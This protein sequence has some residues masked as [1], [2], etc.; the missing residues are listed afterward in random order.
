MDR[1]ILITDSSVLTIKSKVKLPPLARIIVR[2]GSKLIVDG[3]TLTNA[4]FSMWQG[5]QVWGHYNL[6]QGLPLQGC[7]IFKNGAVVENA[8]IGV[9]ACRTDENGEIDWRSTGGIIVGDSCIFRN[10][11]EAVKF[12]S[13]NRTNS[14]RFRKVVFETTREF[15]DGVSTPVDF[16][17][18]FQVRGV[19]F[20]GCTFRNTTIQPGNLPTLLSG[21]GIY[22]INAS[23]TID[24]DGPSG[25]SGLHYGIKAINADPSYWINIKKSRFDGNYRGIYLSA[26]DFAQVTQDT[27][28]VPDRAVTSDTCYGLYLD[29]CTAY[30]VQENN[31]VSTFK[32]GDRASNT[33]GIVVDNS[34]TEPNE[35]YNNRFTNIA[36]GINSQ[37]INRSSNGMTGLI[38]KCNDFINTKNDNLVSISNPN[39]VND[40]GIA[41]YQGDSLSVTGP[42]GNTFSPEH[43]QTQLSG[44]DVNNQG[45]RFKYYH[46]H[47]VQGQLPRVKPDFSLNV[48]VR[49]TGWA[50]DSTKCCPSKLNGGGI[51]TTDL[52][53]EMTKESDTIINK[54]LQLNAIIDGGNTETLNSEILSSTPP[55]SLE[56]RDQLLGKSPYLSDTTM[57]SAISKED[58]LPNEIIRD[59]LV[60]NPQSATSDKVLAE[61]NNRYIPM[62]DSMMAEI[63]AGEDIVSAKEAMEAGLASH[64]V[65]RAQALFDL[66]NFYQN[67]TINPSSHD[68][69][70][71]I[72]QNQPD[73][74]LKYR[75]AFK[76]LSTGDT[77]SLN[78]TLV[79]IPL[80]RNLDQQETNVHNDYLTYFS[81]MKELARNN[82]S[83]LTID[84]A[85]LA[86]IQNL[87]NT[88]HDPVRSIVR[89]ILIARGELNYHEPILLPDMLKSSKEKK[90]YMTGKFVEKTYMRIFPNPARQ[91]V[92][93]EYNLKEKFSNNHKV[94]LILTNIKGSPVLVKKLIK[95]QDQELINTSDFT[96]GTY[97]CSLMLNGKTLDNKKLVVLE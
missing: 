16:I 25:F 9:A 82:K 78:N 45:A 14:S 20:K 61:M 60:A 73:L 84:S 27:L 68:S 49:P 17:S 5:V 35:I 75:L 55:E 23:Y 30:K 13:Y 21:K 12:V 26:V 15:I 89:N 71:A 92:I 10:N 50:F 74:L 66:I 94:L 34:G 11:Y 29:H 41:L 38:L 31:F 39:H 1:S 69:L 24:Q 88:G 77:N 52:K 83:I 67:D 2:P 40:W 58:V 42:A 65:K 4:C 33:I 7:A 63:I 64:K 93:V 80:S 70:I 90:S 86:L 56:L 96:P 6:V 47:Q 85:S 37:D 18:L 32:G 3:G 36:Y 43:I 59:M 28:I 95:R 54:E 76:Y 51:N 72:L 48:T 57:Q 79:A 44:S 46:H 91:Y 81:V 87:Y 19:T 22:S 53:D 97:I 62:P 8:R